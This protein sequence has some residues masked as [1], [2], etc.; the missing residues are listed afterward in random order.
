MNNIFAIITNT[1]QFGGIVDK[2]IMN[3]LYKIL[4]DCMKIPDGIKI[5]DFFNSLGGIYII[6]GESKYEKSDFYKIG[7][8]EISLIERVKSYGTYYPFGIR[9]HGLSF[10]NKSYQ[11]DKKSKMVMDIL[12]MVD[13]L[14]EENYDNFCKLTES[15]KDIDNNKTYFTR[16]GACDI[17]TKKKSLFDVVYNVAIASLEDSLHYNLEKKNPESKKFE[18]KIQSR[19]NYGEFFKI[20]KEDI[21]KDYL[22]TVKSNN[23]IFLYFPDKPLIFGQYLKSVEE[24]IEVHIYINNRKIGETVLFDNSK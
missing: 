8:A 9:V 11:V 5:V 2:Y 20:K 19:K 7:M 13:N 15:G 4:K 24:K 10:T 14:S 16:K 1:K 12:R 3:S 23:Q 6:E 21:L 22:L 17:Y 18:K